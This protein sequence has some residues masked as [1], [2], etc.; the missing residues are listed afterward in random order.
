VA[1]QCSIVLLQHYFHPAFFLP[2]GA[3][4]QKYNYFLPLPP[5]QDG[6]GEQRECVICMSQIYDQY[7]TYMVT[8]CGHVFHTRCL[9][10][11]M[12]VKLECP[13]CRAALPEVDDDDLKDLPPTGMEA[14]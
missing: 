10:R 8:P 7:K 4:P 5:M 11:W 9:V 1:V 6:D 2:K 12:E 3:R 14:V 13:T